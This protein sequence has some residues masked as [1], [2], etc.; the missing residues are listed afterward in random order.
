EKS[1][2][3]SRWLND[4][5]GLQ[6]E[7]KQASGQGGSPES[8]TDEDLK[9]IAINSLMNSDAERMVPLLEKLLADPKAS[10]RLKSRALFVLGQSRNPHAGDI[11][12]R[13]AK[14]TGNPDVQLK[15]VEYLGIFG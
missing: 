8:Q 1:Y 15:A 12:A 9:L 11:I 13:Y 14:S 10:P 7:V 3:A 6:L 4:A 5:R 2:P